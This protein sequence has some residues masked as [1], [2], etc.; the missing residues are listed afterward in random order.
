ML[1]GVKW[2]AC[3]CT[4]N[5]VLYSPGAICGPKLVRRHLAV[6]RVA[7]TKVTSHEADGGA[8][9]ALLRNDSIWLVSLHGHGLPTAGV[10]M[11]DGGVRLCARRW[12]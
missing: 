11:R 12:H 1:Q 6:E 2:W 4:V 3:T 5:P 7:E 9:R 8:W 10:R